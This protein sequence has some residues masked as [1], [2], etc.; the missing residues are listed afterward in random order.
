MLLI[1]ILLIVSI[2]LRKG[3]ELSKS[4]L[5]S[6][7]RAIASPDGNHFGRNMQQIFVQAEAL[8]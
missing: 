8:S 3:D 1:S 2:N 4:V 6:V 5:P 7:Y